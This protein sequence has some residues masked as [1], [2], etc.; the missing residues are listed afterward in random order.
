MT[1]EPPMTPAK[2]EALA[3]LSA[4]VLQLLFNAAHANP[5]LA[6]TELAMATALGMRGLAAR[7]CANNPVLSQN[8]A[9]MALMRAFALAMNA[10]P[11]IIKVVR[12]NT[13]GPD[14][15]GI[16]PLRGRSH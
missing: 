6:W 7:E 1:N 8:R 13:P 12:E 11:E 4:Q 10:P 14:Q 2:A 5:E 3:D 15:V 9:D 16:I